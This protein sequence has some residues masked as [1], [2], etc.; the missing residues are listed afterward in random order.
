MKLGKLLESGDIVVDTAPPS[1]LNNTGALHRGQTPALPSPAQ[2]EPL[3]ICLVCP[4]F[5]F[6]NQPQVRDESG[7]DALHSYEHQ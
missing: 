5:L 6:P 2:S 7:T 1:V 4:A 3:G